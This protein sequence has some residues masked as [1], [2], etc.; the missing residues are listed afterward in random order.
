MT[1]CRTKEGLRH[2]LLL[3]CRLLE[4]SN[5]FDVLFRLAELPDRSDIHREI[6][7]SMDYSK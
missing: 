2:L 6:L 3:I 4:K 7:T 1:A 5:V